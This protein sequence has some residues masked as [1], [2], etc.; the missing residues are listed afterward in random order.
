ME[1]LKRMFEPKTIAVLGASEQ[2]GTIG[3]AIVDNL[4]ACQE[5]KVY[6]VEPGKENVC[7]LSCIPSIEDIAE[8]IDL[9]IYALPIEDAPRI[10]DRLGKKGAAGVA[11]I[12][13]LPRDA[14]S[15]RE[16]ILSVKRN[17]PLRIIGP[18]CL[19]I[20]R[21]PV[22]LCAGRIKDIP[23]KG[24]VAFI[25]HSSAFGQSLFDWGLS[26]RI[27]FSMICSLGTVLDVDVGDLIDFLGNDPYTKS[28]II[29][30]EEPIRDLKR[31]VSAARGFARNKPI[32]LLKPPTL[33]ELEKGHRSHTEFLVGPDEAFDALLA[34]IGVV[35]VKE[36][37]DLYDTASALY[38]QR[39]PKGGALMIISNSKGAA[40]MATRR[41]IR[42]GGWPAPMTEERARLLKEVLP[43]YIDLTNPLDLG[44]EA[45]VEHYRAAIQVCLRDVDVDAVLILFA[46]SEAEKGGDLMEEIVKLSNLATKP[47]IVGWLGGDEKAAET[48]KLFGQRRI[49]SFPTPERA[50]RAC[51]NMYRYE[52]NIKFIQETPAELSVEESPPKNHL[53]TIVKRAFRQGM[54]VLPEEEAR[55]FLSAYG[56]PS[57]A[58]YMARDV[59]EA[60]RWASA[61]GY[62]VVLKVSSPHIIFRQD[63]GGVVM[64]I[65]NES[66]LRLE[67]ERLMERLKTRIPGA[68]II[69]VTVQKMVDVI[70]YELILGAKRDETCGAVIAFG[71]GGIGVEVFSDFSVGLPPLNQAL[72]RRMIE[73]TRVYRML[74]GYRGKKP[75]D[76]HQL[77]EIIVS[78]SN[79]IVDFPEIRAMDI[80]PLAISDGRAVALDARMIIDRRYAQEERPYP[81]LLI[82][83]YPSR[84]VSFWRLKSGQEVVL[85][86]IR[87]EDEPLEHEMFSSLSEST[88]RERFYQSIGDITHEMH[89]RFCNIDY[90]REMTMVG[91]I[92]EGGKRRI[93]GIGSFVM[94]PSG[95]ECEFSVI[96]HDDFQGQGLAAK[97]LD[98]LIGIADEKGVKEFFGYA[99]P[100]N[101]RMIALARKLGMS[102]ERMGHDLLKMTLN[103]R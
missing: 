17:Y 71:M 11:I 32:I 10:I 57:I 28:I 97:L 18:N 25:T 47:L 42:S 20:I 46:P 2:E 86:P 93:I 40:Q 91:E 13:K 51:V 92:R 35:R 78:F 74:K 41:L 103:L 63:V 26:V 3:R 69:G 72:A 55:K 58:S 50:V 53:K 82:S 79:L 66:G 64:G 39:L 27:G 81:H 102:V 14:H 36:V 5:K 70:D 62:P 37:Q 80:N 101:H 75:A 6:V 24:S 38:A 99:E 22:G 49:P 89:A 15:L 12:S 21:P 52:R 30:Q 96:I 77:E 94:E 4:L 56:I 7:G 90:D 31:F 45:R 83:P 100:Q 54:E 34:R 59:D 73:D 9:A 95:K 29:Y 67:Y 61:I 68:Y 88:L 44:D 33:P 65:V 60:A 84:Y 76:L 16:E 43:P 8:P 23:I 1:N 87:P 48:R 98:V 85:R 19:G